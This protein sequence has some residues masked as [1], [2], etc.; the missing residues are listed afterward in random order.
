MID[1]RIGTRIAEEMLA[2]NRSDVK[3]ELNFAAAACNL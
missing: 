2:R 1:R 3:Y